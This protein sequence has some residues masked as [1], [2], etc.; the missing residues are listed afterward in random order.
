MLGGQQWPY[1]EKEISKD[2][3]ERL[4]QYVSQV[5]I[6]KTALFKKKLMYFVSLEVQDWV[7]PLVWK[8]NV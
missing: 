4:Q 6:N 5:F 8:E 1:D 2:A 7:T 3:M